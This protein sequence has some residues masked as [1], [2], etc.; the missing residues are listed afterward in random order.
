MLS[1]ISVKKPYYVV[2]GIILVLVL[3]VISFTRMT[4]DLLPS[5]NFPYVIVYVT[6]PGATP[7]QIEADITR[8]MES[9]FSTLTDIKNISSQSRDSLSL[10]VLQF[11][12]TAD[13]NTA[14]IEINSD[15]T[16]LQADWP[17]GVGAPVILKINPDLMP[18]S[19]VS[20]SR[21]D[22]DILELSRY[23]SDT[24]IPKYES[25]NGVARVSASGLITE[26][27]D[28]TIEQDRI[29][30]LNSAILRDVDEELADVERQLNDAQAQISDGKA[31]LASQKRKILGQLNSAQKMLD[32]ADEQMAGTVE[33]LKTQRADLQT[34]LTQVDQAITQLEPAHADGRAEGARA[35]APH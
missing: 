34:Q 11:N 7:E 32:G 12:D 19:I 28:I 25:L 16:A 27:V 4:T 8:P 22:M 13:M 26:E 30:I 10:I 1:R 6:D 20:V 23:V 31:M 2:V 5:M 17:D 9:S 33:E 3:G 15:I 35:K 18:V 21:D 24:L 14:M 29:D